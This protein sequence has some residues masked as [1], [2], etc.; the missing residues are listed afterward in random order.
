MVSDL[1]VKGTEMKS[2]GKFFQLERRSGDPSAMTGASILAS[3]SNLKPDLSRWKT[4]GS[5]SIKIYQ[6]PEVPAHSAIN[7]VMDIDD[8]L[9]GNSAPDVANEK[10]AEDGATDKSLPVDSSQDAGI[11][12]GNV[13]ISGLNHLLRPSLRMFALSTSCKLKLSKVCVNRYWKNQATGQG[14]HNQHRHQ[15]CLYVV[16]YSSK[17]FMQESL[18]AE[19]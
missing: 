14:I 13:K 5:A 1:T 17:R 11:E 6:G 9:E 8:G 7:D 15:A 19:R 2:M 12:A 18:M 10:A 4:P 3:I 16:Q